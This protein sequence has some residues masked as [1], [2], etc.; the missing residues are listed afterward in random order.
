MHTL[1]PNP[2][3]SLKIFDDQGNV[4]QQK[5]ETSG[6]MIVLWIALGVIVFLFIVIGIGKAICDN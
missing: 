1:L 6:G 4:Q 2:D 5:E 3:Y